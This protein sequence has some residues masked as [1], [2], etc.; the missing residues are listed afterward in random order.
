[1]GS[2]VEQEEDEEEVFTVVQGDSSISNIEFTLL[3]DCFYDSLD[4]NALPQNEA[5]IQTW[6]IAFEIE[7]ICDYRKY[8]LNSFI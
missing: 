6:G 1:M 7:N 3:N 5:C 8:V 2:K 4:P